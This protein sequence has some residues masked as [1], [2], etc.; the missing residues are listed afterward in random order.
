M[1][2][3]CL[4][5]GKKDGTFVNAFKIC[6]TKSAGTLEVE[7]VRRSEGAADRYGPRRSD[8]ERSETSNILKIWLVQEMAFWN[9][10][11]IVPRGSWISWGY[12]S[13]WVFL[14]CWVFIRNSIARILP[15]RK[16]FKFG[17]K[18]VMVFKLVGIGVEYCRNGS[19]Q[20]RKGI[21]MVFKL[22]R[23]QGR[24]FEFGLSCFTF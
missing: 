24:F 9:H 20:T 13:C 1:G 14:F 2:V 3:W 18:F 5:L 10:R 12:F 6:S 8:D 11:F 7:D 22:R 16:A 17:R 21:R 4:F 15:E 19:F 23:N